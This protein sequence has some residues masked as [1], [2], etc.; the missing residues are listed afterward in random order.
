MKHEG[1]GAVIAALLSEEQVA[2]EP[3]HVRELLGRIRPALIQVIGAYYEIGNGAVEF[4]IDPDE[5]APGG[6]G[7]CQ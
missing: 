4:L 5:L 1:C 7:S 2:G 3:E 6:L